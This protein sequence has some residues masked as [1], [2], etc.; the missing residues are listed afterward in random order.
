MAPGEIAWIEPEPADIRT[1]E[2]A[3]FRSERIAKRLAGDELIGMCGLRD[4]LR[5]GPYAATKADS[6]GRRAAG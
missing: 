4:E 1:E 2:Y 5:R 3:L 6:P